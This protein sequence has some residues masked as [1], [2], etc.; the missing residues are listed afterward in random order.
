MVRGPENPGTLV[1]PIIEWLCV[2]D[3]LCYQVQRAGCYWTLAL[4]PTQ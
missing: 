2:T 1:P 4:E 3:Q